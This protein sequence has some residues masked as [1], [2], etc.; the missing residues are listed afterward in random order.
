MHVYGS[1]EDSAHTILYNFFNFVQCCLH[2]SLSCFF[3]STLCFL[4]PQLLIDRIFRRRM[5]FDLDP[6]RWVRLCQ[7]KIGKDP[8]CNGTEFHKGM[9]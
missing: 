9:E 5:A 2:Y 1:R 7:V 3:L 6:E 4:M 8:I